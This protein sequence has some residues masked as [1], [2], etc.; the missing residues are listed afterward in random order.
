MMIKEL[1]NCFTMALYYVW[2]V[3]EGC[4]KSND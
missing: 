1:I 4:V 2:H 3:E